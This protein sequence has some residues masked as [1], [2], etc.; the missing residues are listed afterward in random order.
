[1]ISRDVTGAEEHRQTVRLC[2]FWNP[3][4]QSI[5]IGEVVDGRVRSLTAAAPASFTSF[6][7]M[8]RNPDLHAAVAG[9]HR[10]RR[11]LAPQYSYASLD[12]TPAPEVPHL[13]APISTQEVWACGE[14]YAR[15]A[16][17]APDASPFDRAYFADRP[18]LFF[19][20]TPHRVAGPNDTI[21]ARSDSRLVFPEPELVLIL[22][23]N[24]T[25][26]AFTAGHD[27]T[28]YDL[29]DENVLYMPQVKVFDRSCALGPTFVLADTTDFRDFSITMTVV[30]D[31][32]A[33]FEDGTDL[34]QMIRPFTNVLSY[35]F[36]EQH[37]DDGVL[38]MTGLG[39]DLPHG[40]TIKAGDLVETT[41]PEI[42]TLRNNVI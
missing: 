12:T 40:F 14:T 42:G 17:D 32:Q 19:K 11:D 24:G 36:R 41:I 21:R 31:G 22:A 38:L 13:L 27:V 39:F 18:E 28:A 33:V 1:M 16:S 23:P 26:V 3:P 15:D 20:S 35:L 6:S 5:H 9:A 30:R 7:A 2:R 10:D 34:K 8:L 29:A 25:I 37:F 4:D